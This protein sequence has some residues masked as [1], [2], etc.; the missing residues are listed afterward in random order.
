MKRILL[1][2]LILIAS[3]TSVQA[4]KTKDQEQSVQLM[5]VQTAHSVAFNNGTLTLKGVAPTT[6]FF[7]DR[8]KREVGH[9]T[10]KDFLKDWDKGKN[11]FATDPPNAVL[12]IFDKDKITD[13]VIVLSKPRLKDQN[14][15]YDVSILDGEMPAAGGE[16][17]LFID[18]LGMPRT[19]TSRAGVHRRERRRHAI[20]RR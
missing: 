3:I 17:S 7:A 18:P 12:S 2:I 5:F 1:L 19:P 11:S 6:L 4:E 14:L 9:M 20:R 15:S 10:M 8:P 13:V 16:S